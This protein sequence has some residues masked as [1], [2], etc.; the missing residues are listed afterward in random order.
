MGVNRD[1]LAALQRDAIEEVLDQSDVSDE[2]IAALGGK[3]LP[4]MNEDP[5]A[6]KVALSGAVAAISVPVCARYRVTGLRPQESKAMGEALFNLASAYGWLDKA[7]PRI[8]AWL[9]LGG[10]AMQIVSGREKLP[11]PVDP[12]PADAAAA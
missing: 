3:S 1:D 4:E 7:D 12:K 6:L 10:V 11:T 8:M 9:T 2:R 5:E